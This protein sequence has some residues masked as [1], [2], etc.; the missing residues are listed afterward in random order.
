LRAPLSRLRLFC[1]GR[2]GLRGIGRSGL[3]RHP[4]VSKPA[5]NRGALQLPRSPDAAQVYDPGS[6]RPILSTDSSRF[7]FDDLKGEKYLRYIPNADHGLRGTDALESSLAFYQ[8]FLTV[9]RARAS[10]GVSRLMAASASWP[11]TSPP[12]QNSGR[13]PTPM[14]ATS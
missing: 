4:G 6:G 13:P 12:S 2:E 5:R 14:P 8:A 11:A 10:V 1:A 7:Y 3:G 9:R